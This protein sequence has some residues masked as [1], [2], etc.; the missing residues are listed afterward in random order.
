V[1]I[2]RILVKA[3]GA[4]IWVFCTPTRGGRPGGRSA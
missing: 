2:G 4:R 1:D 3:L